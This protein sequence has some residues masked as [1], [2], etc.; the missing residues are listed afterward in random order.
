MT[1]AAAPSGA[2]IRNRL[3]V[4]MSAPVRI[5]CRTHAP[6]REGTAENAENA[7]PSLGCGLC[8]LRGFFLS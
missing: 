2:V 1:A 3:R 8:E 6:E 4:F 7:D 5:I